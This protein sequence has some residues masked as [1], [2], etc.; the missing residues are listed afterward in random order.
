M[1]HLELGSI[2]VRSFWRFL[3]FN[4]APCLLVDKPSKDWYGFRC[5]HSDNPGEAYGSRSDDGIGLGFSV[6]MLA[7]S[8][9]VACRVFRPGWSKALMGWRCFGS[10]WQDAAEDNIL[11]Q[12]FELCVQRL[13]H[14]TTRSNVRK[15]LPSVEANTG[16]ATS[17]TA[18]GES[19]HRFNERKMWRSHEDAQEPNKTTK[20]RTRHPNTETTG[21]AKVGR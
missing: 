4:Q 3:G 20:Q 8:F 13:L 15:P 18:S 19:E 10:T 9:L 21:I 12:G 11:H 14:L 1:Q 7:P 2:G 6:V 17:I 16:R 5:S